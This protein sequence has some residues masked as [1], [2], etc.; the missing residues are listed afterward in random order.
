MATLS[1]SM[2]YKFIVVI[3]LVSFIL[4]LGFIDARSSRKIT[5]S[6]LGQPTR[7]SF[8]SG[9]YALDLKRIEVPLQTKL[10]KYSAFVNDKFS[11]DKIL[12]WY[13]QKV[14]DKTAIIELVVSVD[15]GDTSAAA[16]AKDAVQMARANNAD[17][18]TPSFPLR[19][20]G[21]GPDSVERNMI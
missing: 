15:D 2:A 21:A 11:S 13:I 3:L 16:T 7:H 20:V 18:Y 12:K 9:M 10:S 17:E 1:D 6:Y 5:Q 14:I 4:S 19:M 8:V